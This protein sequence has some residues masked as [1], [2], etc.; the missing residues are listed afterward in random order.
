M[1]IYSDGAK[2]DTGKYNP[3]YILGEIGATNTLNGKLVKLIINADNCKND[4]TR[5]YEF[6]YRGS[7]EGTHYTLSEL[8]N[9]VEYDCTL[10]PNLGDLVKLSDLDSELKSENAYFY[11]KPDGGLSYTED[12]SDD[13]AIGLSWKNFRE[14]VSFSYPSVKKGNHPSFMA[15]YSNDAKN[16]DGTYDPLKMLAEIGAQETLDGNKV[17]LTLNT[18]F[19]GGDEYYYEFIYRGSIQG[20]HYT[21]NEL[22]ES[23]SDFDCTLPPN[24]G[25]YVS[26]ADKDFE[27]SLN[28]KSNAKLFSKG[29]NAPAYNEPWSDSDTM[30][31]SWKN[32][33]ENVSF[34]YPMC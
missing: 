22:S 1:T 33:R 30:S 28:N 20:T 8:K 26:I 16:A 25:S 3:M 6:I 29:E 32:V 34:S 23:L 18:G 17:R 31:I 24:M 14:N 10:P 13:T 7:I 12:Y 4:K 21:L 5:Y 11:S 27:D 15:I 9:K 2:T 19:V